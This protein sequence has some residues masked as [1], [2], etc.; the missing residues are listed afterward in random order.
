MDSYNSLTLHSR[1]A[2]REAGEKLKDK[3]LKGGRVELPRFYSVDDL[4]NSF[5]RVG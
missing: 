2:G 1:T 4:P 5:I 3:R